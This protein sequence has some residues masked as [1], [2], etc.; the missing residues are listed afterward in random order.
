MKENTLIVLFLAIVAVTPYSAFSQ[1]ATIDIV[2]MKDGKALKGQIQQYTPGQTLKFQTEDGQ[3][4]EIA[5]SDVSKIQQ[6]VELGTLEANRKTNELPTARTR[7]LY[8]NSMLSFAVGNSDDEGVSLGAG[9]SQVF[10]KQINDVFGLGLGVGIDNYSRRGE[11]VYPLFGELRA[12]FPSKKESGGFYS[13]LGGGYSLGFPRKSLD[14]KTAEGGPMGY[15][16]IGY[17]AATTEGVD[18]YMDLGAR[19]QSAHFER[20]LYNGDLE[21]RDIDYRRIVIRVGIGLWK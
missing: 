3:K 18:I 20:T 16:A 9:F 10:G 7:G 1:T 12:L 15:L 11:T 13:L 2:T 14:I 6:G 21:I 4:L 5:D 17:R 8:A 19:F